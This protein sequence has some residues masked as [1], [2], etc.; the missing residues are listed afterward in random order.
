MNLEIKTGENREKM[1][2]KNGQVFC[3]NGIFQKRDIDCGEHIVQIGKLEGPA[4]L[5]A[6]GKY[7]IP[8]LI[9]IH[10][11]GAVN[12]DA[13]DGNKEGLLQMS[14]YYAAKG[15]TSWCPTTMALPEE[16]LTRAV[17]AIRDFS[18]ASHMTQGSEEN[19]CVSRGANCVG[20]HLEGPFLSYKKRGAQRADYLRKP[21]FNMFMRL[22]EASGGMIRLVTAAPEEDKDFSFIRRASGICRVSLG[23][24]VADYET[25]RAAFD[26]GASHVTHLFNGMNRVHHR[27]PGIIGAA[28]DTGATVE[29]ICDG[30][31]I[32]PP[33]IRMAARLFED[34]MVLISDSMRCAGMPDG[35]YELGGQS[36]TVKEGKAILGNGTLAGSSIHLMDALRNAVRF[37]VPLEKAVLAATLTPAKVIGME[38]EIGRIAPGCRGDLLILDHDLN[39]ETVIIGGRIFSQG[40]DV[41]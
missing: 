16:E 38:N 6:Q 18:Q 12:E 3:E 22:N 26:A 23:H 25:A 29:L 2:I 21:D 33:A 40:T 4:D 24:S 37:G 30:M 41:S 27:E 39:L 28:F 8:G 35:C 31:H 13:S 5:D 20:I 15:V 11:H 1:L 32:H 19:P 10:S 7:V 36:V 9:D 14:L 17:R 34:R